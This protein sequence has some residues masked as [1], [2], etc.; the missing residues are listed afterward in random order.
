MITNE[1][2]FSE[3]THSHFDKFSLSGCIQNF[4]GR[5]RGVRFTIILQ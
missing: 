5:K 4:Q 1:I 2:D 3:N